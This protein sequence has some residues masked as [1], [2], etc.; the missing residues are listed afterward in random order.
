MG[1]QA[2]AAGKAKT[3]RASGEGP[4]A[5]IASTS[6]MRRAAPGTTGPSGREVVDPQPA[7]FDQQLRDRRSRPVVARE[8][9][10]QRDRQTPGEVQGLG[11]RRQPATR[12][13]MRDLLL[14]QLAPIR[15]N[16]LAPSPL[17]ATLRQVSPELRWH[18]GLGWQVQSPTTALPGPV[19]L[20]RPPITPS[21]SKLEQGVPAGLTVRRSSTPPP[22]P[23]G[24][25][26]SRRS[27][28]AAA[29]PPSGSA[30]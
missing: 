24:R 13:E 11:E 27:R 23:R 19:S 1:F 5:A 22:R 28:R 3:I 17:S 21:R 30:R 4:E 14:D 2:K 15:Q 16:R 12:L 25:I 20:G 26:P 29:R 7:Q 18:R 6:S 9:P 8:Q 10:L